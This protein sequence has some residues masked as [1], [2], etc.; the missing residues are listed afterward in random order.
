[1]AFPLWWNDLFSKQGQIAET[2]LTDSL[3]EESYIT[4]PTWLPRA[5]WV[6]ALPGGSC[7]KFISQVCGGTM[8]IK[9]R[10]HDRVRDRKGIP[11]SSVPFSWTELAPGSC[12]GEILYWQSRKVSHWR[13]L[14]ITISTCTSLHWTNSGWL[15]VPSS[16]SSSGACTF[17]IS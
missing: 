12:Q 1:M 16:C 6:S 4:E 5:L 17:G 13:N 3:R 2:L 10:V 14:N 8:Q 9:I 7:R 11:P 15:P